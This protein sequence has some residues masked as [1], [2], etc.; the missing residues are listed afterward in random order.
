MQKI[1][2]VEWIELMN[3]CKAAETA[4]LL[5]SLGYSARNVEQHWILS[6]ILFHSSF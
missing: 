3:E 2:S 4:E 5:C 6:P 1:K